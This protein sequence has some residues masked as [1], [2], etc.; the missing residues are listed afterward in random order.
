MLPRV[1]PRST[2]SS[3]YPIFSTSNHHVTRR[4]LSPKPLHLTLRSRPSA[5][6][7]PPARPTFAVSPLRDRPLHGRPSS[8]ALFMVGPPARPTFAVGPLRDHSLHSRPSRLANIRGRPSSRPPSTRSALPL[9]Q[10]SWSPLLVVDLPTRPTF[11]VDPLRG[12]PSQSV[13]LHSRTTFSSLSSDSKRSTVC[14]LHFRSPRCAVD[15]PYEAN[16]CRRRRDKKTLNSDIEEMELHCSTGE[17][18]LIATVARNS[19]LQRGS[20]RGERETESS[21]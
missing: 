9:G 13:A 21:S 4:L 16:L 1:R 11:T 6:V 15:T 8:T 7:G 20:G 3:P 18:G 5:M 10:P 2:I 17:G 14:S 19:S 12:W